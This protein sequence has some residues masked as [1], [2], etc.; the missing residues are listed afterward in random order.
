MQ[1]YLLSGSM[2]MGSVRNPT[3]QGGIPNSDNEPQRPCP[4]FYIRFLQ[5]FH[6][7]PADG[8][9]LEALICKN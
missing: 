2:R 6:L 8:C 5:R 7:S 1:L 4:R 3:L 9:R